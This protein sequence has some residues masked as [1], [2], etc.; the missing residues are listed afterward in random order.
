[1]AID[2]TQ[3]KGYV[4]ANLRTVRK[5]AQVAEVLQCSLDRLK[6][7]FYRSEKRT[8][9]RFI[10]ESKVER[11]KEQLLGTTE[12]CKVICLDLGVREDVGARLF[13]NTTGMT[14]EEFRKL[15]KGPFLLKT[16]PNRAARQVQNPQERVVLTEQVVRQVLSDTSKAEAKSAARRPNGAWM[17]RRV[18]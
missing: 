9:S 13:K 2:I 7:S 5:A 17:Q 6:K 16:S 14:M 15:N 10:R 3:V 8:L 12:A 18:N 11:M 1:M 4:G